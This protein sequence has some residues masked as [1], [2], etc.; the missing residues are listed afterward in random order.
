MFYFCLLSGK[1]L[2][3]VTYELS[4]MEYE[5]K[6]QYRNVKILKLKCI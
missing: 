2:L 3:V 5:L 1:S 6:Y 4:A